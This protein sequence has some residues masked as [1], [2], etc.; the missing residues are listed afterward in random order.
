MGS[1]IV[2][3]KRAKGNYKQSGVKIITN[4]SRFNPTNPLRIRIHSDTGVFKKTK[5]VAAKGYE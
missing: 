4:S 2:N 3:R 5:K 1:R